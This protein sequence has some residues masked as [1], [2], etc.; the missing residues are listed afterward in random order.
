MSPIP[1]EV[2]MRWSCAIAASL[3]ATL[4]AQPAAAAPVRTA[5]GLLEGVQQGD[6]IVYKGVPFAAPPTGE[7]RWRPPQPVKSWTGVRK[8]DASAPG[9]IQTP[10]PP[11]AGQGPFSE[12]CL[13]LNVW[14]PAKADGPLPVMLWF[15]GGGFQTGSA[16]WD[17]F[18]ASAL[19][20]HGVMVVTFNYRLGV[21]GFLAH[22][23]LTRESPHHASGNYGE[24]DAI[25]ALEWIRRNAAALGGDPKR[26]TLFGQSAGGIMISDLLASPEARGLF[27]GVIG[28]SNGNFYP[29]DSRIGGPQSLAAAEKQGADYAAKL[30]APTLEALRK[31]P[32]E[33]FLPAPPWARPIV[34]GWVVPQGAADAFAAGR[35]ID[36]PTLV[37]GNAEEANFPIATPPIKAAAF[38]SELSGFK[39]FEEKIRAAYPFATDEEAWRARLDFYSDLGFRWTIWTWAR[40][41][42]RMGKAPVYYYRF[43]QP[44]PLKDSALRQRL[45]APHASEMFFVF[46]DE[47]YPPFEWTASDRE[48]AEQMAG[49]WTNFAKRGDPNGPGLPPWPRFTEASPKVMRLK[50]PPAADDLPNARQLDLISQLIDHFH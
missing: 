47:R 3:A 24:M 28:E 26:V 9:C 36:V 10:S 7:L 21:L 15:Y 35:Q 20:R 5:E 23:E 42:I 22:P 12:D 34:D 32:A 39:P 48:L 2:G 49:Y 18:D 11:P 19:A 43:E 17:L 25:A 40:L 31:L 38:E 33:K 13:Y 6:V 46:Q 37:G 1:S 50:S 4:L 27:S 44:E 45:G 30:G 8:A 14:R 29:T 16:G 41:Q